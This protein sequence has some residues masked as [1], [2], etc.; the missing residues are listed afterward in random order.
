[1]V[2]FIVTSHIL[3]VTR[4][5]PAC[6]LAS[7]SW[8][9]GNPLSPNGI[10]VFLEIV[11]FSKA[12]NSMIFGLYFEFAFLCR[13][14]TLPVILGNIQTGIFFYERTNRPR[15][16]IAGVNHLWRKTLYPET[17]IGYPNDR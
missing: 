6:V 10:H 16:R 7:T 2:A 5:H 3:A 1:M 4:C 8:A 17:A 13:P 12:R 15:H 14:L 9:I 11:L